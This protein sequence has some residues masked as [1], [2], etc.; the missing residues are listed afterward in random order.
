MTDWRVLV[1]EGVYV[2]VED[3]ELQVYEEEELL[4]FVKNPNTE[5]A[6][7]IAVFKLG[8]IVG[9]YK[10]DAEISRRSKNAGRDWDSTRVHVREKSKKGSSILAV[11]ADRET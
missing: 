5:V 10:E 1:V 11:P 4:Y 8:D 6:Q 7:T 9:A 3:S 2:L